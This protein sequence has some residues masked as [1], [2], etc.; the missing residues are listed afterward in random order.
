MT[1]ILSA[2]CLHIVGLARKLEN[3]PGGV[4]LVVDVSAACRCRAWLY[5]PRRESFPVG[6]LALQIYGVLLGLHGTGEKGRKTC[7]PVTKVWA[8]LKF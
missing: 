8:R 6:N 3:A 4:A 5:K 2:V 7:I 1:G